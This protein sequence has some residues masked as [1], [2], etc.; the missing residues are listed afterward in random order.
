[1]VARGGG[2]VVKNVAGYDLP[3]L[4]TGSLGTL[5]VIVEA[6]FRLY[7]LPAASGTMAMEV[8]STLEAGRLA[9][10]LL[11]SSLVPGS[12]DYS[13]LGG[14]ESVLA[15][16]FESLPVA[17]RS[18]AERAAQLLRGAARFLE[19]DDEAELWSAFDAITN[20]EKG[21]VLA[22][23]ITAVSDLPRLVDTA[24]RQAASA[25][26]WLSVRAHVGHGH[27]LLRWHQPVT[28]AII[29]M[30]N[31]LRR[32][33]EA[34][35]GNLVLWRAPMEVRSRIDVWGSPGEGLDLM[36]RIK[37]QFDPRSTLNPGRFVGTI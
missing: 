12:L 15:V 21:D 2:K 24:L 25:S 34:R 27:A 3:K 31:A 17:V 22:R 5:G 10:A 32:E 33:A 29:S 6:T 37:A 11:N 13:T 23:L 18:Q 7:P 16:R 26:V 4:I 1:V 14:R 20:T 28:E 9:A 36:K 35:D 30:F 19:G 8:A